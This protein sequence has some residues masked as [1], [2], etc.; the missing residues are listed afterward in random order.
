MSIDLFINGVAGG[1]FISFST[2]MVQQITLETTVWL[3]HHNNDER[4]PYLYK[5]INLC[6]GPLYVGVWRDC[7]IIK[8]GNN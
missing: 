1:I 2:K 7:T 3:S 6:L 4:F 8:K 5:R